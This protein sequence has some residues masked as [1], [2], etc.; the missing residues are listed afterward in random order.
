MI[1]EPN[2]VWAKF[3]EVIN[4]VYTT[5]TGRK[6]KV[7]ITGVDTG[8]S[9]GG[10]AYA[11]VEQA[12]TNNFIVGLKGKDPDK[13]RRFGMDTTSYRKAKERSDLYLVEVNQLKDDLA[14]HMKLTWKQNSDQQQPPNFM[15]YPT[16]SGGKYTYSNY[17]SHF[18]SEHRVIE[19][20]KEGN[21][22]SARWIKKNSTSQNHLWDCRIYNMAL[23]DIMV[24]L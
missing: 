2:N 13:Y 19:K 11:F 3:I 14:E 22:V 18:E 16:P 7:F 24:G 20:N 8:N 1:N 21:G 9:Y 10:N 6:M 4:K 15:N 5:D 17:Y 12:G 23:K